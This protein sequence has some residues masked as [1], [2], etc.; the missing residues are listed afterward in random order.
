MSDSDGY[1]IDEFLAACERWNLDEIRHAVESGFLV[2]TFDDD[3][4]TGLQM[5]AATGNIELA[6][7][8][9]DQGADVEKSNQVGMTPLHH[10]A[11]NGHLNIIR[12][13]VQRGANYHKLTFV[14]DYMFVILT[15]HLMTTVTILIFV[16]FISI[17][18]RYTVIAHLS[19]L[20]LIIPDETHEGI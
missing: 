15:V 8:L 12:I 10:A 19:L 5:A 17:D 18:S 1:T 3:H 6:Q 2:D 4:V 14:F 11:K 7:Y 9:L 13:L 20:F 16:P